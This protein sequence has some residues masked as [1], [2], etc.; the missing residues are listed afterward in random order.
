MAQNWKRNGF[1]DILSTKS[2]TF[3]LQIIKKKKK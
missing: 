3:F 2:A 1:R